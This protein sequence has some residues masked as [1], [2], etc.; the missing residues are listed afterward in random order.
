M[1]KKEIITI[2]L[3]WLILLSDAVA[4]IF[5][6]YKY[7]GF[8]TEII[9][10]G[11]TGMAISGAVYFW[12]A[13]KFKNDVLKA[14]RNRAAQAEAHIEEL[15]NHIAEQEKVTRALR[16]SKEKFH[17][18]A[19]HDALTNLPNRNLFIE[20][21]KFL[22]EKT[23]QTPGYNFAVLYLDLNRFKTINESL[24]HSTGDKLI[25]HVAKRLSNFIREGDLVARFGGDEFAVILSNLIDIQAAV[26]FAE[27][28]QEKLSEPFI[29]GGRKIFTGVS[30]GIALGNQDYREA[31]EI[32]R[33]ADIAM[34]YA[35]DHDKSCEIFNRQMHTRA[36]TLLQLEMD[37]RHAVERGELRAFFQ[38]I[39]DLDS[40]ELS[41]FEALIRWQHPQRGL[42]SPAEFIPVSEETGSIVP[43]TLW[44]LRNCCEQLVK[45]RQKSQSNKNLILSINLS[46]KH[47]AEENL[48]QQ[49]GQ[50]LF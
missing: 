1:S 46:G 5:A 42:V 44:M 18:A 23:K 22:L 31:E 16:Q 11:L 24:G 21:L 19:F 30:I 9:L 15:Q 8:Q 13:N 45:W 40:L 26:N 17:H 27:R 12:L 48:V 35:K 49:I 29:V 7:A 50:I 28:I 34:Y 3:L 6:I 39:V 10:A 33:D 43:I 20:T 14:E 41:G 32:L 2:R 4:C 36:V 37:L 47:F 38:P 25:L